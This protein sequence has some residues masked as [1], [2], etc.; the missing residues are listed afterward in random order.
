MLVENKERDS[1]FTLIEMLAVLAIIS[2]IMVIAIPS[3]TSSM[4]RTKAKQDI[5]RKKLLLSYAREYVYDNRNLITGDCYITLSKLKESGY[6]KDDEDM[7]S[8]HQPFSIYFKYDFASEV[9]SEVTSFAGEE[10]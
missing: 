8:N 10:C 6:I 5:E 7:D 3:I 1:G 2:I 4:E 9:V